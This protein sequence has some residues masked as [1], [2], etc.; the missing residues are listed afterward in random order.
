MGIE[1]VPLATIVVTGRGLIP[2]GVGPGG[3]RMIGEL[4]DFQMSGSRLNAR[5]KGAAAADWAV[6][7]P[8][9]VL[10]PDVRVTVETDDGAL[11]Y[12]AYQGR[13]DVSAGWDNAT[14]LVA[15]RFE[16][17]DSRYKWLNSMQAVGKGWFA[18]PG[19]HYEWYELR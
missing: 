16:T 14:I 19:V 9:A 5:M 1:L 18:E 2:I 3:D 7:S 17:S 8:D 13:V 10:S 15:P 11:I 12:I 6:V 4:S